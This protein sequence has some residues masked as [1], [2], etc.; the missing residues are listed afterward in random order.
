VNLLDFYSYSL[1]GKLTAFLQLQEFSQ[2]KH[3]VTCSTSVT[4]CLIN[5]SKVKFNSRFNSRLFSSRS[6]ALALTLAFASLA[7][8]LALCPLLQ[9]DPDNCFNKLQLH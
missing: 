3:N 1:I 7:L 6:L 9:D 5:S 2:R 8:A 4:R